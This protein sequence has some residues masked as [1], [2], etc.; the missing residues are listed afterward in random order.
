MLKLLKELNQEHIIEKFHKSSKTEQQN[1][2]I[3]FNKLDKICR[4][5]IKGY[6]I[7]A[8]KLLEESKNKT[9]HLNDTIIEIPDNIPHIEIGIPE[10][11]ELDQLGF[12][13]LKETVFVLVAGGLGERLGY[14]GI[15]IGLPNDLITLSTYIEIYTDYIKLMK[16]ELKKENICLMNGISLYV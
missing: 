16:I 6:L 13:H 8:K 11:F 2:L 1:F 15:K 5:G 4:G 7:R 12:N 9:N 10:F 14:S 3:Q